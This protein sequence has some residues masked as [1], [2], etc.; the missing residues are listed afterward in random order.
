[1]VA[2]QVDAHTRIIAGVAFW[3][4]IGERVFVR[5][6]ASYD[7]NVGLVVGGERCLVVDTRASLREGTALANAVRAMTALPWVVVNTHAHFDHFLGNAAFPR[8]PIWSSRRCA[9]VIAETGATQRDTAAGGPD[10]IRT[11]PIVA[12]MHTFVSARTLDLGGRTARLSFAGRGH[13]DNDIVAVVPDAAVTFMGDLVEEGAPPAFEDAYPLD[14]PTTLDTLIAGALDGP[15][16][17]GHGAVVD[18]HFVREQ[19]D[20]LARVARA[21]RTGAWH[22]V[23][24]PDDSARIAR[25]RCLTQLR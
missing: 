14:W 17:P 8:A 6:N 9:E 20:L 18:W 3:T 22:E 15:V 11:T 19:R 1:V 4:E 7:L 25:E 24:L 16:V 5:R 21:G 13:T 2:A 10:D 12:P 23:G